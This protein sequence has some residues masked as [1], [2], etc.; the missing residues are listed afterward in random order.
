MKFQGK[1]RSI[2]SSDECLFTHHNQK[3]IWILGIVNNSTK[4]FRLEASYNRDADSMEKFL[5]NN[6]KGGNTIIS[7]RWG[8]YSFMDR[9]GPVYI[10]LTH[11]HVHGNFGQGLNST[12]HIEV[13]WAVL[14]SKIKQTYNMIPS[15]NI[16][17]FVRKMEFK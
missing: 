12:S 16:M 17:A 6:A 1:K 3:Q 7:N 14:K 15:H 8:S 2:F 4:E 9:P 10:N 5:T 11:V 13:I